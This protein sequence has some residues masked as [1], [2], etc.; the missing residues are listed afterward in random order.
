MSTHE[1]KHCGAA[2]SCEQAYTSLDIAQQRLAQIERLA[3]EMERDGAEI[4][5][6]GES[7]VTRWA[8]R[9]RD[10]LATPCRHFPEEYA[11][12][13][14]GERHL[15]LYCGKAEPFNGCAALCPECL[16]PREKP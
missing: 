3:V 4:A 7:S 1:C 6:D 13:Q 12:W 14:R 11:K 5:A 8:R 2:M 10:A 15:C 16:P 9:L